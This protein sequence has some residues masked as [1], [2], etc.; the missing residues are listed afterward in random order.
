MRKLTSLALSQKRMPINL[1]FYRRLIIIVHCV[2]WKLFICV[3]YSRYNGRVVILH[4]LC[5]N[6]VNKK[7]INMKLETIYMN[8]YDLLFTLMNLGQYSFLTI[9]EVGFCLRFSCSQNKAIHNVW[10]WNVQIQTWLSVWTCRRFK[11]KCHLL[12]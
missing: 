12:Q 1:V 2:L 11:W 9:V 8:Q 7:N 5:I 10:F 3:R 6:I 4:F